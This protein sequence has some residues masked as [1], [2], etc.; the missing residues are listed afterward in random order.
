MYRQA[1]D[2][3]EDFSYRRDSTLRRGR[4]RKLETRDYAYVDP[5]RSGSH[6][7]PVTRF[8]LLINEH[9]G[10]RG[11]W[12]L[13]DRSRPG[14]YI[15]PV[16]AASSTFFFLLFRSW[17]QPDDK[18]RSRMCRYLD[19][20]QECTGCFIFMG[21]TGSFEVP[22]YHCHE[23]LFILCD[24]FLSYPLVLYLRCQVR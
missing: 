8:A 4:R 1:V 18:T 6:S 11:R 17:F 23:P 10:H 16:R 9:R 22:G 7:L 14:R 13:R 19:V 20:A 24:T 21:E 12:T 3:P 5:L 15:P 2:I